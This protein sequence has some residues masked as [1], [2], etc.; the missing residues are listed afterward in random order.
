MFAPISR[1]TPPVGTCSTVLSG[2]SKPE[3][4]TTTSLT[5]GV[6]DRHKNCPPVRSWYRTWDMTPAL[7]SVTTGQSVT[8][9]TSIISFAAVLTTTGS[10][11][12]TSMAKAT[13]PDAK[14]RWSTCPLSPCSLVAKLDPLSS[15]HPLLLNFANRPS[16]TAI[17]YF[18]SQVLSIFRHRSQ[19]QGKE[20]RNTVSRLGFITRS[21]LDSGGTMFEAGV[22]R[23]L[24][25]LVRLVTDL[26]AEAFVY[27][28]AGE[29]STH[30]LD[31]IVVRS[32][33]CTER[34]LDR[35]STTSDRRRVS[36]RSLSGFSSAMA[37]CL[38]CR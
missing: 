17:R 24:N 8:V 5:S 19:S 32:I 16:P 34:H 6:Q 27:Q 10:S 18:G 20:E 31:S 7:S 13:G 14:L 29:R 36:V 12:L 37:V 2:Y 28:S 22:E 15:R 25:Q 21:L 9:L 4:T 35:R 30:E 11:S 23:H 26:G 33:Q 1:T 38:S 3:D